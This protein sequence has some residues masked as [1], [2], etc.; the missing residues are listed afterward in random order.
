[1]SNLANLDVRFTNG[2]WWVWVDEIPHRHATRDE[3]LAYAPEY[4][5]GGV[6]DVG[7]IPDDEAVAA[8]VAVAL[9]RYQDAFG[10]TD[11][12]ES[13]IDTAE[14]M[15]YKQ[16]GE[17]NTTAIIFFLK[18]QGR[19]RGYIE[20]QELTGADGERLSVTLTWGDNADA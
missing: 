13:M 18:T 16:I 9:Q 11:A 8:Y 10:I 12:R 4:Q 14:S 17:G 1:M 3:V 20:R 19:Q 2:R 7:P 5:Y 6:P 15:L